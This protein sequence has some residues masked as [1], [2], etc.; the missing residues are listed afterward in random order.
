VL[1][2]LFFYIIKNELAEV[3]NHVNKKHNPDYQPLRNILCKHFAAGHCS[4]GEACKFSH[5]PRSSAQLHQDFEFAAA[6]VVRLH[7]EYKAALD[8]DGVDKIFHVSSEVSVYFEEHE[9][10]NLTSTPGDLVSSQ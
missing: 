8:R 10:I 2:S 3:Y 5:L 1:H 4:H 6:E 9:M 7:Q